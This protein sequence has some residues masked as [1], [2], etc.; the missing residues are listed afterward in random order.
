MINDGYNNVNWDAMG[1]DLNNGKGHN[2]DYLTSQYSNGYRAEN[3]GSGLESWTANDSGQWVK[4]PIGT[5]TMDSLKN[6][7]YNDVT[8]MMFSDGG[9]SWGHSENLT[10]L[11]E[12]NAT[13]MGV[14]FDKYGYTHFDWFEPSSSNQLDDNTYTIPSHD[15]LISELNAAKNDQQAKLTVKTTAD[16]ANTAAQTALKNAKD[17]QQ[18]AQ[19]NL[20]N[21]QTKAS[22]AAQALTDAQQA[23][24]AAQTQLNTAKT[25]QQAAQQAYDNLSADIKTK[26][27][28]VDAA[29]TKLNQANSDLAAAK[30]TL[31]AKEATANTT[32]NALQTAKNNVTAAQTALNT[33]NDNVKA[34]QQKVNDAATNVTKA[35]N[36]LTQAQSQL[37]AAQSNEQAAQQAVDAFHASDA[38]KQAAVNKAEAAL[39]TANNELATA[40]KSLNDAND[41]LAASKKNA[42]TKEQAVKDAQA[43]VT[44]DQQVLTSLQ[45]HLADLQ[46]APAK[47][48][49]AKDALTQA[50]SNLTK[51]QSELRAEQAKMAPLSAAVDAAQAKVNAA[52]TAYNQAKANL[53]SAQAALQAA[54]DAY[55]TDAQK[56]GKQVVIS[57]ITIKDGENV[58]APSIA[59]GLVIPVKLHS[60]PNKLM[61]VTAAATNGKAADLP[62]GTTAQWANA[63]Q[64][65]ADAQHAGNYAEDVLITFPDGSTTTVKAQLTVKA[66]S[67]ANQNNGGTSTMNNHQAGQ[68]QSSHVES[69]SSTG[70]NAG[71]VHFANVTSGNGSVTMSREQYKASQ[72]QA[73]QLPQTSNKNESV[74]TIIGL[75]LVASTTSLFGLKKRHN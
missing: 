14:G 11:N 42:Q 15:E 74:L 40:Q 37:K 55:Q 49:A 10:G 28:A 73:G 71:S 67:T 7:I 17:A 23:L 13:S 45:A 38:Q 35:Q 24:T 72:Q 69:N 52:Q 9:S 64:V 33:A 50:Q 59:N 29:Q 56:Y 16:N 4:N 62:Q 26:Q 36:N 6:A 25:N 51:A 2:E 60:T 8:E 27:A 75:A 48:Q 66:A 63:S 58:P 54:K 3:L 22:Q 57:P 31:Q 21:A 34:Q 70:S 12:A 1:T 61:M 19:T 53:S 44:N 65:A 47:L 39:Q 68:K 43:K 30:T 32:A 18:T 5:Q 46:N 20:T 41:A